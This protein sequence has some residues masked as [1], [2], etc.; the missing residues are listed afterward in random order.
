MHN[1]QRASIAPGY[2]GM[3][4]S[5]YCQ[6]SHQGPSHCQTLGYRSTETAFVM[7]DLMMVSMTNAGCHEPQKKSTMS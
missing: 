4:M 3:M 5:W 7:S 1:K 6:S 2:H